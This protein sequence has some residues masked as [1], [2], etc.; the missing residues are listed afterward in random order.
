MESYGGRRWSWRRYVGRAKHSIGAAVCFATLGS[1]SLLTERRARELWLLLQ[2][3][4]RRFCEDS[5]TELLPF[6]LRF[7]LR[8]VLL[9]AAT[10]L[11]AAVLFPFEA[12]LAKATPMSGAE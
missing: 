1:R 3:C 5:A 12:E 6:F 2:S 8:E 9:E 7:R 4:G 10:P 11:L